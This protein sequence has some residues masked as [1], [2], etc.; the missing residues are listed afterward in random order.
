MTFLAAIKPCGRKAIFLTAA[1]S[2]TVQTQWPAQG[3]ELILYDEVNCD[4]ESRPWQIRHTCDAEKPA[5]PWPAGRGSNALVRGRLRRRAWPNHPCGRPRKTLYLCSNPPSRLEPDLRLTIAPS[6]SGIFTSRDITIGKYVYSPV[7]PPHRKDPAVAYDEPSHFDHRPG[8]RRQG[9]A[10][11]AARIPRVQI[12]I[13][14]VG[15]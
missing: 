15:Q 14:S 13:V 3:V 11:S 9:L 12:D 4:D 10:A 8:W 2:L 7:S 6:G 5:R 1:T